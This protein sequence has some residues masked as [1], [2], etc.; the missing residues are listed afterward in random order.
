MNTDVPLAEGP[1]PEG[2]PQN[3]LTTAVLNSGTTPPPTKIIA[4]RDEQQ[5]IAADPSPDA[6]WI[7]A[8]DEALLTTPGVQWVGGY[9]SALLKRDGGRLLASFAR[10][11]YP[12]DRIWLRVWLRMPN[13]PLSMDDAETFTGPRDALPDWVGRLFPRP[14]GLRVRFVDAAW[15]DLGWLQRAGVRAPDTIQPLF[16]GA[17]LRDFVLAAAHRLEAWVVH[18]NQL[19]SATVAW[20]REGVAIWWNEDL[21]SA[22]AIG[23]RLAAA[24]ARAAGLFGLGEDEQSG[25]HLLGLAVEA[26]GE[27]RL[28]WVRRFSVSSGGAAKWTDASGG[29]QQPAPQLG[30]FKS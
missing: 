1:L 26:P 6:A 11:R 13:Q 30:W 28:L 20:V 12:D 16:E 8:V 5:L 19:S 7:A 2:E 27:N 4:A 10:I 29:F 3:W 9:G 24:G 25:G 21:D 17:H 14:R 23:H 15:S 18:T 22:R